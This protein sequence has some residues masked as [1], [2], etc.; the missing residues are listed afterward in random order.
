MNWFTASHLTYLL[1]CHRKLWLHHQQ[2]RMED[3]SQAV[4]MG[5]FIEQDSYRRRASRWR[6]LDLGHLKIDHFDPEARVI[7]EVKKSAAFEELHVAQVKLYLFAMEQ[8]GIT[9]ATGL[10]EY[11]KSRKRTEV[12]LTE[13]DRKRIIPAWMSE[14]R[15]I[16]E[17]PKCPELVEKPAC[18]GCAFQDFCY[19]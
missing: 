14:A 6:Q 18:R 15:E 9:G 3:N 17:K 16:T 7:R 19:A 11:P 4:A 1:V 8:R 5:K 12:R 2:M 13:A 10:I